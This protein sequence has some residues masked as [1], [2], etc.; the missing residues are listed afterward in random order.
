[1][2]TQTQTLSQ[3][4]TIVLVVGSG[5][6]LLAYHALEKMRFR[7]DC[8]IVLARHGDVVDE[9]FPC[10]ADLEAQG[11]DLEVLHGALVSGMTPSELGDA[12]ASGGSS[13]ELSS[14]I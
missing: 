7:D 13:N 14:L 6:G 4:P 11:A 9:L 10:P 8:D 12:I 1:M 5:S 2:S 3:E